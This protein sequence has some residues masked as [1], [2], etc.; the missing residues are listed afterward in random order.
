M[1]I[2]INKTEI[3]LLTKIKYIMARNV[4]IKMLKSERE[5]YCT[6]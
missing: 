5:Q 3:I 4:D 1:Q 6:A 2:S